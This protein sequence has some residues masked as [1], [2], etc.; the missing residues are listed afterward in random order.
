[1]DL[2][3]TDEQQALAEALGGL[4]EKRYEPRT[5]LDLLD[6]ERGWSEPLWRQYADM[7]LLGL[8]FEEQYGGAGMGTAELATVMEQFGRALVLEPF[9]AGVV[10]GGQLVVAA[11]TPEQKAEILP[12]VAAGE[13]LL[14]FAWAEPAARWS[15]SAITTTAAE[16][17]GEWTVT[18]EKSGVLGGDSADRLVVSALLPAGGIGLFLVDAAAV[19]RSAHA[20]QDGLRAADVR[21][22]SAPA[23]P[24]G[25]PG[26]DALATIE[27][28]VDVATAMLCSEAVGAI[29]RMLWLTVDYLK[30][31][32][33]F[34]TPIA[35][36]QALQFRASDMHVSLEQARSM[37]LMA[38]LA[39]TGDDPAERRRAVRAAKLQVDLSARHVGQ[40]A[41]QLHGGIGM[42]MEYPVGH[43]VKRTTVIAKTFDDT[44]GLLVAV[45]EGAGLIPS[46]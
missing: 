31:R 41:I 8:T 7:G 30:T 35:V 16:S 1:M 13:L 44:D 2:D 36:F 40:E 43:Y 38:Q 15:R 32:V 37:A 26:T 4:L 5:R 28:V 45:G 39:L 34:G 21:L 42:T 6:S 20:Q 33:Q 11:G 46:A 29:D 19:S 17:D 3:P 14:A 9:V 22:A 24:L 12:A 10:L 25:T 27:Q 18:G 23:V